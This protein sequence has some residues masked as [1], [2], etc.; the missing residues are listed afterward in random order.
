MVDGSTE[1][2][3]KR[4]NSQFEVSRYGSGVG[5]YKTVK[6]VV[7]SCEVQGMACIFGVDNTG[8]KSVFRGKCLG[9]GD[10]ASPN[11]MKYVRTCVAGI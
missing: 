9:Y 4:N 10:K 11:Y 2:S 3:L 5:S 1:D 6:L 8:W 7:G